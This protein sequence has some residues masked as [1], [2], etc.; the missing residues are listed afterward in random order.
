MILTYDTDIERVKIQ[1]YAEG[2]FSRKLLSGHTHTHIHN[3]PIALSGL[4]GGRKMPS[5]CVIKGVPRIL[6]WGGPGLCGDPLPHLDTP[7]DVFGC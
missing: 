5:G 4:C 3:G 1:H 2:D 6:V 7:L